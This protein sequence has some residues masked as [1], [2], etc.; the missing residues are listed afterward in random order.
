MKHAHSSNASDDRCVLHVQMYAAK[1]IR[2][3]RSRNNGLI[4][5]LSVILQFA[6]PAHFRLDLKPSFGL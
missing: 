6:M 3:D 2:I 5:V 4:K 1:D